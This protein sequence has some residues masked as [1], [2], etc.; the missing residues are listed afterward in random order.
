[1]RLFHFKYKWINFKSVSIIE[2]KIADIGFENFKN[3]QP[4]FEVFKAQLE[5][6]LDGFEQISFFSRKASFYYT[7]CTK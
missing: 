6:R 2:I 4:S 7:Q 3:Q 5:M 1:V